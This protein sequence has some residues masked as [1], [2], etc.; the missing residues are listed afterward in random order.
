MITEPRTDLEVKRAATAGIPVDIDGELLPQLVALGIDALQL[1][2]INRRP[3]N[4][5]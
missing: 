4:V 5:R 2:V 3:C 1:I